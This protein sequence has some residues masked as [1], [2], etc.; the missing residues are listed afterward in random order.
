MNLAV[1]GEDGVIR[2]YDL[3]KEDGYKSPQVCQYVQRCIYIY[4][5][6]EVE[7]FIERLIDKKSGGCGQWET[8]ISAPIDLIY[9]I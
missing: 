1:G 9:I 8:S 4:H 5:R 3:T 6:G 7:L 2:V